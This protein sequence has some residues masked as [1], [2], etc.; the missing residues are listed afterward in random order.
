VRKSLA[1]LFPAAFTLLLLTLAGTSAQPAQAVILSYSTYTD[2]LSYQHVVGEVQNVGS[3]T[4]SQVT[5]NAS[6]CNPTS[7]IEDY[8]M[9]D[10]LLP[11]EKSPFDILENVTGNVCGVMVTG[12]AFSDK[13]PYRNFQVTSQ[14]AS[15]DSAGI[16]HVTGE[17]N[18]TGTSVA[19]AVEVIATY[20]NASGGVVQVGS[21]LTN[22]VDLS[23]G[24]SGYFD[25]SSDDPAMSARITTF[26]LQ[27]QS[28][29]PVFPIPEYPVTTPV[30]A[31]SLAMALA[32]VRRKI[33]MH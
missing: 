12:A 19:H 26:A 27:V 28:A 11:Q 24:Q 8:T 6:L 1:A 25:V 9:I 10:F 13:V 4:L 21:S 14:A 2:T 32:I 23:P 20:Y 30:L 15:S 17:V 7:T 16:Y 31:V 3:N 29:S 22:P 18:N 5:V 33:R